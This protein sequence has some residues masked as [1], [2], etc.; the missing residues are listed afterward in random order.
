MARGWESK[1]VEDQIAEREAAEAE[2]GKPEVS[3]EE[4]EAHA[5]RQTLQLARARAL[6]DLQTA[7]DTRHRALLE[8]TIEHLDEELR[9]CA[10]RAG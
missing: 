10:R 2:R 8:Q 7:C 1:S 5:R 4:A 6:Q 3:P 9:K